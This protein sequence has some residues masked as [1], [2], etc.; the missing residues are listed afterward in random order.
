MPYT[1]REAGE[2][3]LNKMEADGVILSISYSEWAVV[4]IGHSGS[5]GTIMYLSIPDLR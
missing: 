3:Q 1:L 5:V 2:T 4:N